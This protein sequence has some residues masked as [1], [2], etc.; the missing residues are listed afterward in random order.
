MTHPTHPADAP[1]GAEPQYTGDIYTAV[2]QELRQPP[3]P[4][5]PASGISR[6]QQRIEDLLSRARADTKTLHQHLSTLRV[7][8]ELAVT[9]VKGELDA[10]C[11]AAERKA[12]DDM[13]ALRDAYE[14]ATAPA[15]KLLEHYSRIMG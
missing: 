2:E 12:Q 15:K 7:E 3:D 6:V 10:T 5:P 11:E 9:R 13:K 14:K 1:Y 4:V 8:Y